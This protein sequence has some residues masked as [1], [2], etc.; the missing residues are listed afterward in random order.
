MNVIIRQHLD[1]LYSNDAEQRYASFRYL[2]AETE[3]PV[4]WV[5]FAW[6]DLL[7]LLHGDNHQRS[8]AA[9]LIANLAKSDPRRVMAA[10][11]RIVEIIRDERFVTARHTLQ[12]LWKAGIAA[13]ELTEKITGILTDRF[14]DCYKEKNSTLIRYDIIEVFRKIYDELKDEKIR[15]IAFELI[16]SEEDSKYKQKYLGL[17]KDIL[18]SEKAPIF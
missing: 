9:Q 3:I 12:A 6:D 11:D 1:N 4:N 14:S 2:M 13:P 10:L 8:I 16:D 15:K 7:A 5:G 18:K 17:W